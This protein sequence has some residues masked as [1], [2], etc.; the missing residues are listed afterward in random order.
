MTAMRFRK[1][2]LVALPA[3]LVLN[4]IVCGGET[5]NIIVYALYILSYYTCTGVEGV[6]FQVLPQG[7][8]SVN[9]SNETMGC[10][11]P[12][13]TRDGVMVCDC[14]FLV[15]GISPNIDTSDNDWAAQLVTVRRELLISTTLMF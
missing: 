3:M 9:G 4:I 1:G 6:Q 12:L 5:H 13:V 8:R 15:D 10:T 14:S 7:I 2:I 11:S